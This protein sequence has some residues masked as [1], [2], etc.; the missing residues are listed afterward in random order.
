M[1]LDGNV[2]K[3]S[4][5]IHLLE[6]MIP[7]KLWSDKP[8]KVEATCL[9]YVSSD[10]LEGSYVLY[11]AVDKLFIECFNGVFLFASANGVYVTISVSGPF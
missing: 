1:L 2:V 10:E 11:S 9:S 8:V 4:R 3:C 6:S 7:T 5:E